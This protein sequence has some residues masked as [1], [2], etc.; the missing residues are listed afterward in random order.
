MFFVLVFFGWVCGCFVP[1]GF[2]VCKYPGEKKKEKGGNKNPPFFFA[3][4][5]YL[6][7]LFFVG[8]RPA[9]GGVD[10]KKDKKTGRK[11]KNKKKRGIKNTKKKKLKRKKNED[12]RKGQS[13]SVPAEKNSPKRGGL[14]GGI[15]GLPLR[16]VGARVIEFRRK[17]IRN[18]NRRLDGFGW[19]TGNLGSSQK[20]KIGSNNKSFLTGGCVF[21]CFGVLQVGLFNYGGWGLEMEGVGFKISG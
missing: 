7:P 15:L 13:G 9:A 17:G 6:Q 20:K 12:K 2:S 3:R 21:R 11:G 18:C 5:T 16:Y 10:E 8:P 19:V 4:I 14:E 1:F